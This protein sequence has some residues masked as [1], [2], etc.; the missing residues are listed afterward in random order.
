MLGRLVLQENHDKLLG[1]VVVLA[2]LNSLIN[3]ILYIVIS[4]DVRNGFRNLM[5]CRNISAHERLEIVRDLA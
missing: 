2:Y 3:P 5:L 4:K 1:N